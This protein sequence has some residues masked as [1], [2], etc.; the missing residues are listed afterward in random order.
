M[1]TMTTNE[2]TN[3]VSLINKAEEIEESH[4]LSI[5]S[6]MHLQAQADTYYDLILSDA[7]VHQSNLIDPLEKACDIFDDLIAE[8]QLNEYMS[9]VAALWDNDEYEALPDTIRRTK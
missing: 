4:N 3:V 9:K 8:H 6:L 7:I 2:V 5:R 1:R